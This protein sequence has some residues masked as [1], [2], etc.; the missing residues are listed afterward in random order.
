[1]NFLANFLQNLQ[2]L[3][4]ILKCC[5]LNWVNWQTSQKKTIAAINKG[6]DGDFMEN[7][8]TVARRLLEKFNKYSAQKALD[9]LISGFLEIC[10]VWDELF[11]MILTDS[12]LE[13][14]EDPNNF[15]ESYEYKRTILK[16]KKI[17]NKYDRL[18]KKYERKRKDG[19]LINISNYKQLDELLEYILKFRKDLKSVIE[20]ID[21]DSGI[22][23]NLKEIH[24]DFMKKGRIAIGYLR[25]INPDV[26]TFEEMYYKYD[27]T[28]D[29]EGAGF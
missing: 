9:D 11:G 19:A 13:S 6:R 25:E 27:K 4:V 18:L 21:T 10:D 24:Y 7:G 15:I 12:I 20:E 5:F 22:Y 29:K 1:M 16:L 2:I 3:L 28:V 26:P 14:S 8:K 17:I 23:K